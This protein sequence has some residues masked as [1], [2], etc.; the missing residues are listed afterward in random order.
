MEIYLILMGLIFWG[1]VYGVCSG[2][3]KSNMRNEV[4]KLRYAHRA[5][6]YLAAFKF[7]DDVEAYYLDENGR[8]KRTKEE[9][10]ARFPQLD[11]RWFSFVSSY[12]YAARRWA[13]FSIEFYYKEKYSKRYQSVM[14]KENGLFLFT[15]AECCNPINE[16]RYQQLL[17]M[18]ART[19]KWVDEMRAKYFVHDPID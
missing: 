7:A 6:D 10:M 14:Q 1:C 17:A 15:G 18:D 8:P 2:K 19:N 12:H 13:G 3:E 9:V 5:D 4:K 16:Q 11:R